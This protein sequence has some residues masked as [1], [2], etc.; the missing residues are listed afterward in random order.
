MNYINIPSQII[1]N[2]IK[3]IANT[4]VNIINKSFSKTNENI[5]LIVLTGGFSNCKIFE[6]YFLLQ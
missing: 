5:D 2:I 3:E 4:I 6:K 1:I